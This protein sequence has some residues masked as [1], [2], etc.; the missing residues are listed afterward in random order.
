MNKK[1]LGS[2]NLER[3]DN[4][5]DISSNQRHRNEVEALTT[6]ITKLQFIVAKYNYILSEYQIRY[7][8][9]TFS[10][11]D[12]KINAEMLEGATSTEYKKLLI[13]NISI[14]KEYERLLLE[15]DKSLSFLTEEMNKVHQDTEKLVKENNDLREELEH[16]KLYYYIKV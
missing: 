8:N 11:L 9:E 3:D 4:F 13:D 14:I 15:K 16:T 1:P 12:R 6:E 10:Q 5:E 7:G 2:N